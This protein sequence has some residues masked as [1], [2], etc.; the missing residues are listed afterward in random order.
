M[1][2]IYAYANSGLQRA[3]S[4]ISSIHSV[5][6]QSKFLN[7]NLNYLW[8]GFRQPLR[9]IHLNN[10]L[11]SSAQ[12]KEVLMQSL[13]DN[14]ICYAGPIILFEGVIKPIIHTL[15]YGDDETLENSM[16]MISHVIFMRIAIK[17]FINNT[18]YNLCIS[19]TA[20]DVIQ[21]NL[22]GCECGT[23]DKVKANLASPFYFVG[24]LSSA[25]VI[26]LIPG[27]G[28]YPSIFL[29]TLAYGQTL[30]EYK[31]A[32]IGT[33]TSHRLNLLTAN[34]AYCFGVGASLFFTSEVF[35]LL[36]TSVLNFKNAFVYDAIF[37]FLFQYY[38]LMAMVNEYPL[39]DQQKGFDFF[40][41]SRLLTERALV[42]T[43]NWLIP[44]LGNAKKRNEY[45]AI[46]QKIFRFFTLKEFVKNPAISLLISLKHENV[47]KTLDK[48]VQAQGYPLWLMDYV[49]YYIASEKTLMIVKLLSEE[50]WKKFAVTAEEIMLE[51]VRSRERTESIHQDIEPNIEL[52]EEHVIEEK[53]GPVITCVP[54][55]QLSEPVQENYFPTPPVFESK[56]L[57]AAGSPGF[58][59]KRILPPNID[60]DWYQSPA[61]NGI[62]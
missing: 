13:K 32:A 37:S 29:K 21:K 44:K 19:H 5:I 12:S 33:C 22:Q 47:K 28:K 54:V 25:G 30:T 52:I 6:T 58:F 17:L 2:S 41:Y 34:N 59:S 40:C 7:N 56:K 8:E 27:I 14:F 49:P 46:L 20:E 26:G 62:E 50:G 10:V 55:S 43:T 45:N 23:I 15:P 61:L 24:N 48:I 42:D 39:P 53:E 57:G 9:L 3:W 35:Y 51:S 18:S 11:N 36:L 16:Q 38:I 60:E 31:Y 4:A 1:N